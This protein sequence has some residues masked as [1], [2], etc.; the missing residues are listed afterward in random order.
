MENL[1]YD[2][3][4]PFNEVYYISCFYNPILSALP[5]LGGNI[6]PV[7]ANNFFYFELDKRVW[8]I[9]KNVE[10]KDIFNIIES[11]MGIKSKPER[12]EDDICITIKKCLLRGELIFLPTDRFYWND[13]KNNEMYYQKKHM[14]LFVLIYAVK[15]RNFEGVCVNDWKCIRMSIDDIDM[16]NVYR[17][18]INLNE[19][20]VGNYAIR[21]WRDNR[22]V[23]LKNL[24]HYQHIFCENY[25]KL[26]KKI[27][28]SF[29]ET[30]IL[31]EMITDLF[32]N[33]E[34][35]DKLT[36][37]FGDL[38]RCKKVQLYQHIKLFGGERNQ[39]YNILYEAQECANNLK[40][41]FLKMTYHGRVN[42]A[43]EDKVYAKVKHLIQ[44]EK[45]YLDEMHQETQL[46]LNN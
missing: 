32:R 25:L 35:V 37:I 13:S 24:A 17:G 44:L 38:C 29:Q 22:E 26:E 31:Y 36:N 18:F 46:H 10:M 21:L 1:L 33:Q 40:F 11:E 5:A 14:D 15:G 7:L 42:A 34:Q 41:T 39:K 2:N 3:V 43:A 4:E 6:Y 12:F 20:E 28:D 23:S 45:Q 30:E 16:D 19:I 8:S 27:R 9:Y